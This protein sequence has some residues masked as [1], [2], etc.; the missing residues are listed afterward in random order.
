D[1]LTSLPSEILLKIVTQV[2]IKNFLDLVQTSRAFRNFIKANASKIC[3]DVI[4]SRYQLEAALLQSELKAGWLV[5]THDM[6]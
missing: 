4:R 1:Y 5:P 3:N 6:I 2:P